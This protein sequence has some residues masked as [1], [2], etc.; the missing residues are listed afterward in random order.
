MRQGIGSNTSEFGITQAI[1]SMDARSVRLLGAH[2]TGKQS[3]PDSLA[4]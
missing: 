2:G 1:E 4:A 3:D